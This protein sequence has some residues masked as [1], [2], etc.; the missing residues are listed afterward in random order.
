MEIPIIDARRRIVAWTDVGPE[1]YG[2][3][4]RHG[5]AEALVGSKIFVAF[6]S[7]TNPIEAQRAGAPPDWREP[8]R[9]LAICAEVEQARSPEI[10]R[11]AW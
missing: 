1:V 11:A 8:W 6:V 9:C 3:T 5:Y 10:G 2:T 7:L 4:L